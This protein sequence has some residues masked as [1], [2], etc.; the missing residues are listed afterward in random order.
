MWHPVYIHAPGSNVGSLW[1]SFGSFYP[2]LKLT[3]QWIRHKG[4]EAGD[5]SSI[6]IS[7]N[8]TTASEYSTSAMYQSGA[9]TPQVFNTFDTA[10]VANKHSLSG[11]MACLDVTIRNNPSFNKTIQTSSGWSSGLNIGESWTGTSTWYNKTNAVS[12]ILIDLSHGAGA[13]IIGSFASG[14]C[15]SLWATRQQV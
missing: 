5:T 10:L 13:G 11:Q 6:T 15:I 7:F 9:A 4:V 8:K 12:G 3:G 1:Y 2:G 14:T